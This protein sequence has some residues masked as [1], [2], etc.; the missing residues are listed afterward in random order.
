[1]EDFRIYVFLMNRCTR[2]R[3]Y[4]TAPRGLVYLYVLWFEKHRRQSDTDWGGGG[5]SMVW[6]ASL[7]AVATAMSSSPRPWIDVFP[8]LDKF[9]MAVTE[10]DLNLKVKKCP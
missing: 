10:S 9:N 5:V 4:A 7:A 2:T 1:M 6:D 8:L 3:Q